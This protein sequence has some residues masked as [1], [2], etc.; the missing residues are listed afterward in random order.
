MTKTKSQAH[1]DLYV[2][3]ITIHEG[4]G[5]GLWLPKI[6]A[7]VLRGH[8]DAMIELADWLSQENN[9]PRAAADAF[10]AIGLYRRAYRMGE[11]R[12]AHN[13]A[14]TYFNRDDLAGY[15]TWIRKAGRAGDNAAREEAGRFE[16][17]LPHKNAAKIGRI[18]PYRRRHGFA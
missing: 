3:A 5:P 18:R 4:T 11:P 8:A 1:D 9:R 15:R 12:A 16:T 2:R 7:L 13:L 14:M 6:R 17:R 10:G